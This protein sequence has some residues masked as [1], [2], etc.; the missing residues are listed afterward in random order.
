MLS[1]QPICKYSTEAH[2]SVPTRVGTTIFNQTKT[3]VL[4]QQQVRFRNNHNRTMCR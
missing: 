4:G 3:P 2:G 1:E